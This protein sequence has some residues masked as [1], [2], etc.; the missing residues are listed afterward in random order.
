MGPANGT[1]ASASAAE[2]TDQG[3]NVGIDIRVHRHDQGD[4]LDFV[5]EAVGEQRANRAIDET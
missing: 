5:E 3:G 2:G 4:H 1:P